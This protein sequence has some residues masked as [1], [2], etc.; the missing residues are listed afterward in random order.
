MGSVTKKINWKG[1]GRKRLYSSSGV[2]RMIKSKKMRWAG[3][4]ARRGRKIMHIGYWW[5]SQKERDH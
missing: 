1:F 2:I 4:V 5:E 3:H